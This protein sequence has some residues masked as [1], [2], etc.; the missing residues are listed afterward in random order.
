[1]SGSSHKYKMRDLT[2]IKI[3]VLSWYNFPRCWIFEKR[4][5]LWTLNSAKERRHLKLLFQYQ[6]RNL[7]RD[8]YQSVPS[9]SG[10]FIENKS[11]ILI[12]QSLFFKSFMDRDYQQWRTFCQMKAF[13]IHHK[14]AR[15]N[16]VKLYVIM[17]FVI[18]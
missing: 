7:L 4:M 17:F 8:N 3:A 1:M 9:F 15:Q 11:S 12:Y 13:Q 2:L 5:S 6:P 10:W 18:F 16:T 14:M